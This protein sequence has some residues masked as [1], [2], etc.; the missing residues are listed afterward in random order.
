[1][2]DSKE[3]KFWFLLSIV[4]CFELLVF[5]SVGGVNRT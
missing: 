1:M 5:I 4:L 2:V 3:S